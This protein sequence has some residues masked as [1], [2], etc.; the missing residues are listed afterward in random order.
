MCAA[1]QSHR[2]HVEGRVGVIKTREEGATVQYLPDGR[3]QADA[4]RRN[5]AP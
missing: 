1:V 2:G 4:K 3:G 5:T